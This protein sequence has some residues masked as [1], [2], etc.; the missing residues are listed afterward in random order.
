MIPKF[1]AWDKDSKVMREIQHLVW[2]EDNLIAHCPPRGHEFSEWFTVILNGWE[3][4]LMQSTGLKDKNGVEIFEGDI[5]SVRNH[6]FQKTESS[7]GI[8]IDGDYKVSWNEYDLTWCAGNLLLARIKPY[9]AVIGN[10]YEDGDLLNDSE[11]TKR[12]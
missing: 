8:E 6:P 1:R 3:Y 9:V 5:V 11:D 12:N 4:Q 7:V 2:A 10:V